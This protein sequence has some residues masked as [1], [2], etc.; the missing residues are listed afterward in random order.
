MH[1]GLYRRQQ[2]LDREDPRRSYGC[3]S[4]GGRVR[5]SCA[6]CGCHLVHVVRV[7]FCGGGVGESC[8]T[9]R[10]QTRHRVGQRR[11]AELG[12]GREEEVESSLQQLHVVLV[13]QFRQKI[14]GL[15]VGV[16]LGS[17]AGGVGRFFAV[18]SGVLGVDEV[19]RPVV[20]AQHVVQSHECAQQH[21][22]DRPEVVAEAVCDV[23]Q[24]LQNLDMF[25]TEQVFG[26]E[27]FELLKVLRHR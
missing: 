1:I 24:R 23:E 21:H 14:F 15:Q 7:C 18:I 19:D 17:V 5:C 2:L 16:V 12:G 6:N 4:R 22:P 13:R 20:D 9:K 3:L 26:W 25:F 11:V 10:T 8:E 27:V